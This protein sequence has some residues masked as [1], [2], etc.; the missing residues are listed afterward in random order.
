MA[1]DKDI[2]N[3]SQLNLQPVIV[4]SLRLFQA[5]SLIHHCNELQYFK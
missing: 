1:M 3:Y 2:R 5:L 4:L